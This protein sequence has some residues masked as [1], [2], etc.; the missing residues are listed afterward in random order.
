M[1]LFAGQQDC[2]KDRFLFVHQNNSDCSWKRRCQS[3]KSKSHGNNGTLCLV[4]LS[5]VQIACRGRNTDWRNLSLSW[6]IFF[7]MKCSTQQ[8]PDETYELQ[9]I[10]GIKKQILTLCGLKI[11]Q[12]KL[13]KNDYRVLVQFYA[14][15]LKK[16]FLDVLNC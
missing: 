11:Y 6:Q 16:L 1:A 10:S 9:L 8:T 15:E 5:E 14:L 13:T 7:Q 3:A 2:S 12:G 4:R